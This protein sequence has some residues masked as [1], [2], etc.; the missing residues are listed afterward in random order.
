MKKIYGIFQR[1]R[2]GAFQRSRYFLLTMLMALG[3]LTP[4]NTSA[5]I[6]SAASSLP[7]YLQAVNVT[8]KVTDETGL[9]LPGV[10]VLEKGTTNGTV[11]DA[12]GGYKLTVASGESVLVF[13]FIGM[14]R[15]EAKVGAQS[16]V[17]VT[18]I[19]DA[20]TLSEIVVMGYGTQE[21]KDITGSV[22]SVKS[23][24]FNKGIISSPE[25]L[26][27]GKIAGV[28]ITS[29][30]GEPGSAQSITI[31]GQGSIRSGSQPLFVVDGM[32]LDNSGTGG[33]MNPLNFLNPQDIES[34]DV[35]KDASATAIYGARGANG[36]VLIT[37]KKGKAGHSS[38]NY[39]ASLGI[40]KMA[41]AI[42]V[43]SADEFRQQ[44]TAIG[45]TLVDL[46]GNTDWQKEVTRTAF[47]QNHN[48]TLNG[49][50]DKLT[51]YASLGLQDQD[52]ILKGSNLK[53]YTGRI[54]INQKLLNDRLSIDINLNATNT[55]S[56]R[57]PISSVFGTALSLNPTYPAY[58]ENGKPTVFPD[59]INP[60]T[61]I[62][63]YDDITNT[64]RIIGNISPSFEI[65]K[66]LTYRL[67]FGID[68]S[69]L[70]RDVQ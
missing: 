43:F 60:L 63:L 65:I 51:Y 50:A 3:A 1:R 41:R 53:R 4:R 69:A 8:G 56:R 59:I 49:G 26:L 14:T 48:V 15:Q 28:N 66:G 39:S 67:N 13:S 5:S 47:T 46:G 25:Q 29:A 42:P 30:S 21:K 57:P 36:V 34:I 64:T 27:Q 61:Q 62:D 35:L 32:A 11:T 52:G 58:D 22:A 12:N 45:G 23:E 38:I 17:S 54:N 68:N 37:T 2:L 33:D 70:D 20:E 6:S 24:D 40:S 10:N 19:G 31:R 18:L 16:E 44:V 7:N 55:V 9:P